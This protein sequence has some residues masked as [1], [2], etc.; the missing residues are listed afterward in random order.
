MFVQITG[1]GRFGDVRRPSCAKL[2]NIESELSED[3]VRILCG[4]LIVIETC[5]A[6]QQ[7]LYQVSSSIDHHEVLAA[8]IGRLRPSFF[9]RIKNCFPLD[10]IVASRY[11]ESHRIY[12]II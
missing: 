10:V 3:T 1:S 8:T 7:L 4:E 11:C 12:P 9:G 2:L 6:S 5:S